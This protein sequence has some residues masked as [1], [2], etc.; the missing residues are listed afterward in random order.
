MANPKSASSETPDEESKRTD[1]DL[2]THPLVEKSLG[3]SDIPKGLVPLTGYFGPSQK[4]GMIRLYQRLDFETYFEIPK[5]SIV[6]TTP[7]AGVGQQ[8]PTVAYVR[9]GTA[10][11]AVHSSIRPVEAYLRGGII[12]EHMKT[13]AR[14]GDSTAKREF[15]SPTFICAALQAIENPQVFGL[16]ERQLG[17]RTYPEITCD[18]CVG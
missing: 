15:R 17:E 10:V 9:M 16:S 8:G 1:P 18:P 11:E 6:A 5:E 7:V 2:S 14:R 13:E 12:S 4:S 3:M